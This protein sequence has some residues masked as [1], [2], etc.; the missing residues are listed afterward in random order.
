LKAKKGTMRISGKS[1]SISLLAVVVVFVLSSCSIYN[2]FFGKEGEK[3]PEDLMEDGMIQM[4]K[5]NFEGAAEAFQAVKNRY[6]YSKFA[7]IAEL[8]A[9]DA[10][11]EKGEHESAFESYDEFEKL[12][13]KN[14]NIPYV[15]Y[16]KG[17]CYFVQ[18][19]SIDREQKNTL[20]AKGQF[21]R[22]TRRFPRSDY[23]NKA[24]MNLR[25]CTLYLAENE[26]YV[27]NFYFKMGKYNAAL[28]RYRFLIQNFPDMG[29][30]NKALENIAICKERLGKRE[31]KKKD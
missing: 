12:H 1:L 5:G 27:A 24:R 23:A 17:M 20:L 4:E 2:R 10:L 13:P 28:A 11:F 21:E 3:G 6:P 18:M 9:A 16:Q 8:K 25:K 15:I 26:L 31:A 29:Q 30:Y 7:I 19:S 22:L 14:E